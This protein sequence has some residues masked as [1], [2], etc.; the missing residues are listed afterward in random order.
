MYFARFLSTFRY[1]N[2]YSNC[3]C[4]NYKL[5]FREQNRKTNG[6]IPIYLKFYEGKKYFA[7]SIGMSAKEKFEGRV[8]PPTEYV[9]KAKTLR[10]AKILVA[11]D[12]YLLTNDELSFD[13]KRSYLTKYLT[14]TP[15]KKKL[16]ADYIEDYKAS[17]NKETTRELYRITAKKVRTFDA[18]A[19]FDTINVDWLRR[20]E[21]HYLETMSING[22][23][24]HL[25]NIRT[26]FNWAIDNEYTEKYPFRRFKIKKETV[27][28]RN[29]SVD[30]LRKIRD[31]PC[32]GIQEMHRDLFLLVF[33][34]CGINAIDLLNCR[35]L[36]AGVLQYRRSKTGKLISIPVCDEAMEIIEK[37]RGKNF[38]ISPM[39]GRKT[40][41]SFL[42]L[43]N[44]TLKR[45]GPIEKVRTKAGHTTFK[46]HPIVEGVTTYTARY[47]FASIAAEIGIPRDHIALCLGH[48][49]ADVTSHY[50]NYTDKIIKDTIR[51]VVDYVNEK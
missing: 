3:Y 37:Y 41:R 8:F 28:I 49:W 36:K 50:I 15:T 2:R 23:S 43:W 6:E 18:T 44:K 25:R 39:D 42:L 45:I 17:I 32:E 40:Y 5:F 12:E 14:G 20:F 11:I 47:T 30:Q 9:A 7:V 48:T 38:L 16:F 27:E 19:T 21:H 31:L 51:R 24:I 13:E 26:V 33:Y 35:S 34:L 29:I 4:M 10:L 1:Q 46:Y 22:L